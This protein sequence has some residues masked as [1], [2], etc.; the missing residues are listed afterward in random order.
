MPFKSKVAKRLYQREYMRRRRGSRVGSNTT[1]ARADKN[2]PNI[3]V[4]VSPKVKTKYNNI[5]PYGP[6]EGEG[7][8]AD[9]DGWVPGFNA[10]EPPLI[11]AFG[12]A[13]SDTFDGMKVI[14]HTLPF[15]VNLSIKTLVL[16]EIAATEAGGNLSLS[17][18]IDTCVEDYFLGRGVDLGL[19]NIRRD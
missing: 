10:Y 3:D 19:I 9:S 18:F 7:I 1:A 12:E 4:A 16:Y 6:G 11:P 15:R 17:E 14:G 2:K 8:I 5:L 13:A